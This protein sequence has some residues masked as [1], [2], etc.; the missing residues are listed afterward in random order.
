MQAEKGDTVKQSCRCSRVLLNSTEIIRPRAKHTSI[1]FVCQ[2]M[3]LDAIQGA[4]VTGVQAKHR[5]ALNK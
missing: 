3:A 4:V 1:S 5:E 2:Q